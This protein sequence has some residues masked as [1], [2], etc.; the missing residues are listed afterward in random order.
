MLIGNM[1]C[2]FCMAPSWA[3]AQNLALPNM[4][5]T[6]A[7]VVGLAINVV[8]SAVGP[9]LLGFLSD[10]AARLSFEGKVF[11]TDC[12]G[13]VAPDGAS[14]A[15]AAECGRAS[16]HGLWAAMMIMII[17]FALGAFHF[18]LAS[19]AVRADLAERANHLEDQI[20]DESPSDV[21]PNGVARA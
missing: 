8:A 3:V 17:F 21:A 19:R 18:L 16:S 1:A 4:R 10:R 12:P 15:L 20:A 7:A 13:G 5:S 6:A 2:G 11:L 14:G 9:A